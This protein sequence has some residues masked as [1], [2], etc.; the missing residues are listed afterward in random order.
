MANWWLPATVAVSQILAS[1]GFWAYLKY[2]DD[3]KDAIKRLMMGLGYEKVTTLGLEYLKRG[4]ITRDELD[5]YR[6]Y[7]V[8]PYIA[9][10]GN[11]VAE[12]I[13]EDVGKLPFHSHSKYEV[14]FD[15][16]EDE[17]YIPNVP[18]VTTSHQ[19]HNASER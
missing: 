17:R 11:G 19:K 14:L 10:G 16:R 2:K 15:D 18:V 9:L 6:R 1:S 8:E 4:W 3:S 7:F 13:Y 12:R 5:E